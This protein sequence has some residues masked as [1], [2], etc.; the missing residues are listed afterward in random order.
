MATEDFTSPAWD[1]TDTESRITITA[2]R[3]THTLM[4]KDDTGHVSES[5]GAAHFSGNFTHRFITQITDTS[6][7]ATVFVWTLA[8]TQATQVA[9]DDASGSMYG[10]EYFGTGRSLILVEIEAG[11]FETAETGLIDI[12]DDTVYYCQV[13]RNEAASEFGDLILTVWTGGY[14]TEGVIVGTCTKTLRS[15][16]NY[17]FIYALQSRG[18]APTSTATSGGY[19]E[20]LDLQEVA[21]GFIPYPR[22]R[23]ARGGML[24]MAGGMH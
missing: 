11:D 3:V 19:T 2:D 18:D 8:N 9:I 4:E 24:P 22:P 20:F 10:V 14:D 12:D 5:K 23:G 15:N 6:A 16:Q 7:G 21:G 17:E 13:E 1:E